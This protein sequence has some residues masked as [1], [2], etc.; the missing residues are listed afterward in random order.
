MMS[1]DRS[2]ILKYTYKRTFWHVSFSCS[3]FSAAELY[4]HGAS[5]VFGS[6]DSD[7]VFFASKDGGSPLIFTCSFSMAHEV[8]RRSWEAKSDRNRYS[9]V[10]MFTTSFG[11]DDWVLRSKITTELLQRQPR[12]LYMARTLCWP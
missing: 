1:S 5:N 12:F 2:S 6:G 7:I 9:I 8:T 11:S 10:M 4:A 3:V